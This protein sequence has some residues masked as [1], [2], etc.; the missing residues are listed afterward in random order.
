[1]PGTGMVTKSALLIIWIHMKFGRQ[2][3][4]KEAINMAATQSNYVMTPKPYMSDSCACVRKAGFKC[5][6]CIYQCTK[7]VLLYKV[8]SM[9]SAHY[10][11]QQTLLPL[12][13]WVKYMV[14]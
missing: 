13:P 6:K 2:V 12:K 9:L 4:V 7:D 1:M 11:M 10:C 3:A 14:I 8:G 5:N